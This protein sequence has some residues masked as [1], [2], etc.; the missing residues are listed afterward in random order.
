LTDSA[1]CR[2]W[3]ERFI[4]K[5]PNNA[6]YIKEQGI[7]AQGALVSQSLKSNNNIVRFGT[8]YL[9]NEDFFFFFQTEFMRDMLKSFGCIL[10]TDATHCTT[11]LDKLLLVTFMVSNDDGKGV[12]V[13]FFLI[14]VY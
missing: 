10:Y 6:V 9:V 3:A 8:R 13:A 1:S 14:K 11:I 7:E 2:S 4:D 12:P 5:N